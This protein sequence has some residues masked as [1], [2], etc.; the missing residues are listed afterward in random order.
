MKNK[1]GY[2]ESCIKQDVC[3]MTVCDSDKCKHFV[4]IIWLA[5]AVIPH[6]NKAVPECPT[7]KPGEGSVVYQ[8][9]TCGGTFPIKE[10]C[11]IT[12]TIKTVDQCNF[13]RHCML[14]CGSKEC[15][16]LRGFKKE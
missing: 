9:E 12:F 10:D 6:V 8:C 16:I 1:Y 15:S 11:G 3:D 2:D 7:C 14:S 4:N 5:T 13:K